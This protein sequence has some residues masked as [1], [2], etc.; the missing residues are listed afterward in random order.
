MTLGVSE[1]TSCTET[2]FK[3][4]HMARWKETDTRENVM[5]AGSER[6]ELVKG[7]KTNKQN[8]LY[9]IK[10]TLLLHCFF[11][12]SFCCYICLLKCQIN[13]SAEQ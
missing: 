11:P 2:Q 10:A 3:Q 5:A 9:L 13:M 1:D 8:K 12:L 7:D 6:R 4:E